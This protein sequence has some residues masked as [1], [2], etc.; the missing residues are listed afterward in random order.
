MCNDGISVIV[1]FFYEIRLNLQL[2]N[3]LKNDKSGKSLPHP[4]YESI[5]GPSSV[6]QTSCIAKLD[7]AL[8]EIQAKLDV[9]TSEKKR[10]ED[11]ANFWYKQYVG[12]Q[13]KTSESVILSEETACHLI[14]S[15]EKLSEDLKNVKISIQYGNNTFYLIFREV[16]NLNL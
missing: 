3:K 2:D 5:D 9:C 10:F 16:Q 11:D 14:K 1:F 4:D 7:S 8:I 12:E 15:I 6:D 13:Q